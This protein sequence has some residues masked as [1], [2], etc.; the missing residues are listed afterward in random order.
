VLKRRSERPL[1]GQK[2]R[3]C[4]SGFG[5]EATSRSCAIADSGIA[6]LGNGI[7]EGRAQEPVTVPTS[8]PRLLA[9]ARNAAR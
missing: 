3:R 4:G 1:L 9:T 7:D 2:A 6:A 5:T 8:V